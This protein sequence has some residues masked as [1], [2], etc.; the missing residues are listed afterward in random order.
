MVTV[1][2]C[3]YTEKHSTVHLKKVDF[4]LS[5]LYL[6]KADFKKKNVKGS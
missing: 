2:L 3:E 5:E 1:Q 4:M 6:T